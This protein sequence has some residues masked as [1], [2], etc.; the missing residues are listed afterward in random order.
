MSNHRNDLLSLHHA[1][2]AGSLLGARPAQ[3]QVASQ[4]AEPET[5]ERRERALRRFAA[6]YRARRLTG[7]RAQARR[8]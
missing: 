6:A 5:S 4:D 2:V 1:A 8:I 3:A 7:A